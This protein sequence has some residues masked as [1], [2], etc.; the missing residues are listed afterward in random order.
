MFHSVGWFELPDASQ[1]SAS[2]YQLSSPA[3]VHT[4]PLDI[5]CEEQSPT[6]LFFPNVLG[7]NIVTI[8]SDWGNTGVVGCPVVGGVPQRIVIVAQGTDGS[9]ITVSVSGSQGY[10]P[11][12][13]HPSPDCGTFD[14]LVADNLGGRPELMMFDGTNVTMECKPVRLY[15]DCDPGTCGELAGSCSDGF[16]ASSAVGNVY[17]KVA[18]CGVDPGT[19]RGSWTLRATADPVTGL[20]SFAVTPP[21]DDNCLYLGCTSLIGSPTNESGAITGSLQIAGE[22]AGFNILAHSNRGTEKVN[23]ALIAGKGNGSAYVELV[24]KGSLKGAKSISIE[25]VLTNGGSSN[26]TGPIDIGK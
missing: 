5:A 19:A 9:G 11:E 22:L 13:A 14:P 8:E 2:A 21:T 6:C 7:D 10:F 24:S 15:T 4:G 17:E 3:N 25:A 1:V 20:A 18:P 12:F 26:I 16:G 23:G